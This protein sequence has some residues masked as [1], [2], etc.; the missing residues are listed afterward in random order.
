MGDDKN[1]MN[2]PDVKAAL[3][4]LGIDESGLSAEARA[5]NSEDFI[6]LWTAAS[7]GSSYDKNAWKEVERQLVTA[8]II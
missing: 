1:G 5:R 8:G 2:D 7:T 6:R 3:A 4:Q